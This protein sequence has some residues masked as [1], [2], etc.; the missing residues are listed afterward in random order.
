MEVCWA[1]ARAFRPVL[2][3]IG[4]SSTRIR[5]IFYS[6]SGM[7]HIGTF[8]ALFADHQLSCG[9]HLS[10]YVIP[11]GDSTLTNLPSACVS[12][13]TETPVAS[14]RFISLDI[15]SWHL[16]SQFQLCIRDLITFHFVYLSSAISEAT[17]HPRLLI[18]SVLISQRLPS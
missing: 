9:L 7:L 2:A 17:D 6:H 1:C 14:S 10:A 5:T 13:A 8:H 18:I 12:Y 15:S 11:G 3:L 16:H 4:S